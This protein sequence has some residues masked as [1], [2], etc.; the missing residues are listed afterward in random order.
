MKTNEAVF[1]ELRAA[2]SRRYSRYPVQYG[3]DN[4]STIMLPH[5]AGVKGVCWRLQLKACAELAAGRSDDALDDVK[6]MLYMADSVK[7]EPFLISYLVRIACVQ[8][9]IQPICEG[10]AEHA[11]SD[12]QL[13]ELETRLQQYNFVADMKRPLDAE[14]ATGILAVDFVR[15][16]GLGFLDDILGDVNCVSPM[17]PADR[18]RVKRIGLIIPS[19]WYYQEQLNYCRFYQMLFA[20]AF[21][22]AKK[23]VTPS[24]IESNSN[25]VW[26]MFLWLNP[27]MVIHHQFIA[28]ALLP[29]LVSIPRRA[30]SA[31]TAADQA[32]LGC[33][34]ERYR[35]ANGQ[36]PENLAALAPRFISQLPY[37]VIN[38]EPLKYR[39][40]DDGQ[41]VL[42]SVGWNETDD[43]GVVAQ[44]IDGSPDLEK[45]DWVWR[46][47]AK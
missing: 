20:G 23:R 6:L 9:A 31:Q 24:R 25:D 29:A 16:K 34:L 12:A 38:G 11:W 39:R 35:L 1:A 32:A 18:A 4:P 40:T 36:F 47:P 5:L 21:D 10:L 41:F 44:R 15:K 42:Y 7:E 28:G 30:A 46:Y 13:Q 19:G 17:S 26:R 27:L 37:D 33:A 45:G 14:R 8:I 3:M 22:A 2:S 43:G